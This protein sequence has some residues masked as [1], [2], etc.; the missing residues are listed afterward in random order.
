MMMYGL[1]FLTNA[2]VDTHIG[3]T[4]L[5]SILVIMIMLF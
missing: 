3:Q 5:I 4:V 2:N 1:E